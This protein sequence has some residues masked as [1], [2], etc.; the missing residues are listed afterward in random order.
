MKKWLLEDQF[1]EQTL[2]VKY[3]GK[4]ADDHKMDMRQLGESLIGI[5]RLINTG[6]YTLEHGYR[7]GHG[8]RLKTIGNCSPPCVRL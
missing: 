4:D 7:P 6:L 1:V 5:E 2:I 3:M 8:K